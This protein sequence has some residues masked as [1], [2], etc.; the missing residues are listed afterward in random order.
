MEIY[1]ETMDPRETKD[2]AWDW[3]PKLSDGETVLS[4][5]VEWIDR[6][7][8]TSPNNSVVAN[9]SRVWL[10][11]GTA[12]S[13]VIW[14]IVALTDQDRELEVALGVDV[15]DSTVI[16]TVAEPT[17]LERLQAYKEKLLDARDQAADGGLVGEVWN[18][19]YGTRM[20]YITMTYAEI[21][22]A[23]LQVDRDIAAL[24]RVASGGS[25]R[26]PIG[27]TWG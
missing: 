10:R 24:E 13:R 15:V 5:T 6:G 3:T 7:G 27:I 23:L 26:A 18:G 9:L 12:G 4:H 17:E 1:E 25:R 19:R 8:T 16:E 11:G 14:T 2:Y 20:K 22:K 21:A